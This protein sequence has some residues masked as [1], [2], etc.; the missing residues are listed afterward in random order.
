MARR[1]GRPKSV[2]AVANAIGA[3][4]LSIFVPCHRVLG[5]NQSLTG[6]AGG[7][8]AKRHPLEMEKGPVAF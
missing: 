7:L 2:R 5:A 1:I 4:P 8:N 6:Y 3:N